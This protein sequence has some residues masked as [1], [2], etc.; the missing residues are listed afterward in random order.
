MKHFLEKLIV[1]F[2]NHRTARNQVRQPNAQPGLDIGAQLADGE[3]ARDRVVID[4]NRRAEGIVLIGK[5]GTGKTSLIRHLQEADIRA[6]RYFAAYDLH[7]EETSFLLKAIASEERR[8]NIDLSDR[9]IVVD[10]ADPEFSVGFNPLE[11]ERRNDR[12]VEIAEFA[13]ILK[14]RWHLDSFGARTDELL[15]NALFVLAENG[16]TII[17]LAPLFTDDSFRAKCLTAVT[18][19]EVREY[20]ATRY[21]QLSDAMKRV[22]SEPVLNKVSFFVSDTRFRHLLGQQHSTFSLTDAMDFGRW[23]IFNFDKG[24]LAEQAATVGALLLAK[25]KHA[26]F[27][28]RRRTLY[29]L[30]CDEVQ[31]LVS[32][33]GA[34]EELM[35]EIRKRGGSTVT[36]NQ[37]LGQLAPDIQAALLSAGSFGFFQLSGTDAQ[38]IATMLDGGK[39]L[40]ERLKNLPR[41]H[42]IVKTVHERWREALVPTVEEPKIDETDLYRRSR[43][44]WARPRREIEESIRNR[45]SLGRRVNREVLDGWE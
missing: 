45:R 27:S 15:R 32:Y 13:Q 26:F 41:R 14:D 18:N 8:R 6:S 31:N 42:V 25:T 11:G 34:L 35:A 40:A 17:E 4:Q 7:G 37:F 2:W 5:T 21:D 22:M 9:V 28:R 30:Y 1:S 24:R 10:P 20:F 36:A 29:P 44:R 23:V 38:Q 12:F 3:P 43:D 39:A 33:G 16:L 19:N